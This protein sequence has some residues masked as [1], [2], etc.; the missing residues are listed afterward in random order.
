MI[1]YQK[2]EKQDEPGPK[3]KTNRNTRPFKVHQDDPEREYF[4]FGG[5][6]ILIITIGFEGCAC[7]AGTFQVHCGGDIESAC[8]TGTVPV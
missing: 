6:S 4:S 5:M 7:G 3:G 8:M 1:K 2:D